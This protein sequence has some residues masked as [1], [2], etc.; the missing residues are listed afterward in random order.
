V[1]AFIEA[2]C[3]VIASFLVWIERQQKA[4]P[5]RAQRK[6]QRKKEFFIEF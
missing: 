4:L 1:V 2:K 5:A 6:N 3:C